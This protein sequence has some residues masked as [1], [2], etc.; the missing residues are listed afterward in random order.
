[1]VFVVLF[2]VLSVKFFVFRILFKNNYFL[3]L[4]CSFFFYIFF[5]LLF[6]FLNFKYIYIYICLFVYIKLFVFKFFT[7]RLI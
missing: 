4:K 3:V 5:F 7:S 2:C 6:F 1:M